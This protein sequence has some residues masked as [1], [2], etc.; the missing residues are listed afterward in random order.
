VIV[1][2]MVVMVMVVAARPDHDPGGVTAIGVMVMVM[3]MVI[4]A[5]ADN[6][7]GELDVRVRRLDR[8]GFIY[9]LQQ[10]GRVRDG[11]E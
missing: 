8:S 10:F 3:M 1:M 4:A 2:M 9:C 5:D 11:V 6:D 7:L